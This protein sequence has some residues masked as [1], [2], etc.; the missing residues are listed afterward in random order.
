MHTLL[1]KRIGFLGCGNMG[2]AL[3]RGWLDKQMVQASH[4][5][6]SAKSSASQTAQDLGVSYGSPLDVILASDIL[7]LAIKPQQAT[8]C[9]STWFK[10]IDRSQLRPQCYMISLLAGTSHQQLK[11]MLPT[12][13]P[14]IRVMPNLATKIAQGVTLQHI[15]PDHTPQQIQECTSLLS[16]VGHV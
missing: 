14:V 7:V 11:E 4:V 5:M 8:K 3:L 6:I 12:T 16:S 9:L 15:S 1:D 2:K 13:L 10:H